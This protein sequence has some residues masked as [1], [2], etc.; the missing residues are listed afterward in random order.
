MLKWIIAKWNALPAPVRKWLR[1]A[2]VAV[3][4]AIFATCAVAPLTDF[5][6]KVAITKFVGAIGA[7]A[8]GALRLYLAQSPVQQ[9]IAEVQETSEKKTETP[10][11]VKTVET[12][13]KTTTLS[14]PEPTAVADAVN[15]HDG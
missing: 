5:H 9:V 1:G 10:A 2:E 6:S 3:T 12:A 7:S 14:G 13:T 8:Y 15:R 11:G 4:G